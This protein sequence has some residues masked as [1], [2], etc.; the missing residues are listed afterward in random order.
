MNMDHGIKSALDKYNMKNGNAKSS[1][2]MSSSGKAVLY[3][4]VTIAIV[5]VM[6]VC[7]KYNFLGIGLFWDKIENISVGD[8]TVG[9]VIDGIEKEFSAVFASDK[10]NSTDPINESGE[11]GNLEN[12]T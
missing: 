10:D 2:N 7:V 6:I 3:A 4:A 1:Q 11:S 12:D 5:L 9:A 8:Q